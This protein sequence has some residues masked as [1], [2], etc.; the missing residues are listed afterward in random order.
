MLYEQRQSGL[1]H[2]LII[3]AHAADLGTILWA[4][5]LDDGLH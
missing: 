2:E 5:T 4:C 3:G 1:T